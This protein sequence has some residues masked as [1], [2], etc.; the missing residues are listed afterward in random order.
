MRYLLLAV[1]LLVGCAADEATSDGA[2]GLDAPAIER[3]TLVT[4]ALAKAEL[5][6]MRAEPGALQRPVI[7]IDGF[8]DPGFGSAALARDIRQATGDG[9]VATISAYAPPTLTH[10]AERVLDLAEREFPGEPVDL[11]GISMGGLAAIE[12]AADG[13]GGR[14]EVRR[15]FTLASPLRGAA[16]ANLPAVFPV[17]RQMR[18]GSAYLAGLPSRVES[19]EAGGGT[20]VSYGGVSDRT[21][22]ID[23]AVP[24]S[25]ELIWLPADGSARWGHTGVIRDPRL[26]A[27][28]INRLRGAGPLMRP[29]PLP[30]PGDGVQL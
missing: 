26:T 23:E 19:F 25:G 15:V 20:L 27:D 21:V 24:P 29:R 13:R 5:A 8:L 1:F 16:K 18:P 6:A 11:V 17:M 28:L 12:A 7:V 2:V 3:P 4:T 30:G 9:R 14:V 10:Y 22:R